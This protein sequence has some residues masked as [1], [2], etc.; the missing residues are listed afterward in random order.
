M[1]ITKE[2]SNKRTLQSQK[3]KEKLYQTALK[4]FTKY[5]YNTV[6]VE[7]IT[8]IAGLSKGTFYTYFKS[9]DDILLGVFRQIDNAYVEAFRDIPEDTSARDRI[10]RMIDTMTNYCSQ[11]VGLP[12]MKIVYSNQIT[13]DPKSVKILNDP[14]RTLYKFLHDFVVL[15]KANKELPDYPDDYF[16]ELLV[17]F[18]RSIIYDWC[19][20]NGEF[21]LEKEAHDYFVVL[22]DSFQALAVQS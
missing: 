15:G 5:G 14:S 12:F 11:V 8:K 20:Y 4:L 1:A 13:G 10:L 21:D 2:K 18:A 19:L 9:K 17:R 6:T 22:L 3:T 16:T 7:D